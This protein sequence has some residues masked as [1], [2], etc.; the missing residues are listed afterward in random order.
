MA[1]AVP[2]ACRHKN[3]PP[4]LEVS[5]LSGSE[6]HRISTWGVGMARPSGPLRRYSVYC[7]WP[8]HPGQWRLTVDMVDGPT[9]RESAAALRRMGYPV[10]VVT[11]LL[12]ATASR[13]LVARFLAIEWDRY[14]R[15]VYRHTG[16]Y[17]ECVAPWALGEEP[18]E[19]EKPNGAAGRVAGRPR[20][21]GGYAARQKR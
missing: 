10:R 13:T 7:V 8:V 18:L 19:R 15:V 3:D 12:K 9:A 5:G 21:P 11:V 20:E 4:S 2:S 6:S 16:E 1:H 17:V 14:G